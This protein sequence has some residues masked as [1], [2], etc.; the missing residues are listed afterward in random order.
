MLIATL[1]VECIG[2]KLPMAALTAVS[3]AAV[4]GLTAVHSTAL[5]AVAR[6]GISSAFTVL[7]VYTPEVISA[8][9]AKANSM[10]YSHED[11]FSFTQPASFAAGCN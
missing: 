7:Y 3:G 11:P 5:I 6:C 2:R 8:P 9:P 1:A 4:I 10:Y